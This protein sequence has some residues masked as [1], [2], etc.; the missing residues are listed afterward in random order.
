MKKLLLVC[1][2]S[3]LTV[4]CST[5]RTVDDHSTHYNGCKITNYNGDV[6]KPR[7]AEPKPVEQKDK[8][9]LQFL[10]TDTTENDYSNN[11][12]KYRPSRSQPQWSYNEQPQYPLTV[13]IP[14]EP[15]HNY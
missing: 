3:S 1:T 13:F 7:Q 5:T 10:Q 15:R 2:L 4:G 11:V 12:P 8:E 9:Y 14:D 6:A